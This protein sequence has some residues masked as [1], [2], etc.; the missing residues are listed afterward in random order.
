LT[1]LVA[2]GER[3]ETL[4]VDPGI[5]LTAFYS[6]QAAAQC[7]GA[8]LVLPPTGGCELAIAL[9]KPFFGLCFSIL[10]L[11]ATDTAADGDGLG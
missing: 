2:I 1:Y 6:S 5:F 4:L 7:A 8:G 3:G 9:G 11:A 10:L